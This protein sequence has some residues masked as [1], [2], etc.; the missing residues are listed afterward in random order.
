MSLHDDC[1]D[2]PAAAKVYFEEA[3]RQASSLFGAGVYRGQASQYARYY[4][5][6][7]AVGLKACHPLLWVWGHEDP[8]KVP[9]DDTAHA[10]DIL[11]LRRKTP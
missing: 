2:L 9:T 1:G 10:K 3:I 5:T 8:S 6:R 7:H 11:V 4:R